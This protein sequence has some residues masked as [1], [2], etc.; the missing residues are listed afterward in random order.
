MRK[1]VDDSIFIVCMVMVEISSEMGVGEG[2]AVYVVKVRKEVDTCKVPAEQEQK[3]DCCVC[4][5]SQK[6]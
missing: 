4:K 6:K 5:F 3:E 1:Q 2:I